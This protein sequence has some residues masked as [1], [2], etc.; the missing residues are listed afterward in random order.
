[1]LDKN[2]LEDLFVETVSG[3]S[4]RKVNML[5]YRVSEINDECIWH[6]GKIGQAFDN[7]GFQAKLSGH[8]RNA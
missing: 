5:E 6:C 4:Y 2:E 7:K 8:I 1:M 3:P